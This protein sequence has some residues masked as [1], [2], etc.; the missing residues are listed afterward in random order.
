M[1]ENREETIGEGVKKV[2]A[3]MEHLSHAWGRL[4][5][6][7]IAHEVAPKGM[8]ASSLCWPPTTTDNVGTAG[9]HMAAAIMYMSK[10]LGILHQ[11]VITD[12]QLCPYQDCA[13]DCGFDQ[14]GWY[15]CPHCQREFW[16]RECDGDIEDW[17]TYRAGE[18]DAK[19]PTK[20]ESVPTACDLG[21]SWGSPKGE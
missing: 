9:Y 15:R 18:R 11:H 7:G 5:H 4:V 17:H 6:D 1:T 13:W 14:P 3:A 16:V 2:D 8:P 20:P 19:A 12:G 21:P 10:A